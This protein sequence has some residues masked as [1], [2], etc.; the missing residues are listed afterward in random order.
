MSQCVRIIFYSFYLVLLLPCLGLSDELTSHAPYTVQYTWLEGEGKTALCICLEPHEGYYTYAPSQKNVYPTEV[1]LAE[2]LQEIPVLFP[3]GTWKEDAASGQNVRVFE[4]VTRIYVVFPEKYTGN[5][6]ISLLACSKEHCQPFA[7]QKAL[8]SVPVIA[9]QDFEYKNELETFYSAYL[10][11]E[12]AK[13]QLAFAVYTPKEKHNFSS[14]IA[15]E[16]SGLALRENEK[17][18]AVQAGITNENNVQNGLNGLKEQGEIEAFSLERL[19][20]QAKQ[21]AA[22]EEVEQENPQERTLDFSLFSA[23]PYYQELEVQSLVKALLFGVLAGFILNFMPCV[24]PVIA[25]KLHALLTVPAQGT[26]FF[27]EQM[28]FFALGILAWFVVLAFLFGGLGLT[29][30]Q[31]FQEY[32]LM[33]ALCILVFVLAL[34]LFDVFH[35]PII[36]LRNQLHNSEHKNV[37]LDTFLSGFLA[38]IL[39]TPCSGPLL[40]GVLGFVLT[41]SFAVIVLVFVCMGLGMALPYLVFACKP[42]LVSFMPRAGNWLLVLEKALAFFLLGTALY[43]F[44]L[45]P[46]FLYLNVLFFLFFLC[47]CL[48]IWGK[49]ASVYLADRQK[50]LMFLGLFSC[51]LLCFWY[52]FMQPADNKN[53]VAW[54][55]FQTQ[56]FMQKL[57]QKNLLVKFTADWCPTCKVLEKTVFTEKN[58]QELAQ[59]KGEEIQFILVDMTQFDED[60]QM[61]LTSLG[62]ASIPFLAVFPKNNPYEPL[63]VRDIYTLTTVRQVLE[64]ALAENAER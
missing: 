41:Q 64:K 10:Q 62:S 22:R 20:A 28:L 61:F 16:K 37:K 46:E 29:W 39:A 7:A 15:S 9:I 36:N 27:R 59:Q 32:W 31:L 50:R 40:G 30:G 3:F 52:L 13:E 47:V 24:L 44:S 17:N 54:Q 51:V 58:M 26:K 45:L 33:L 21:K 43:L 56:D 8:S 49:W 25:L 1:R 2:K 57:G 63:I 18:F 34:S 55:E 5:I 4:G 12:L 11:K 53:S 19:K 48:Y 14:G 6:E 35:L 23:R 38:T 42:S 60:K